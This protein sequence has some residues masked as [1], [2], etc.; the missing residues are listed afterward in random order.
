ASTQ[1][2]AVAGAAA[3][4]EQS[5]AADSKKDD[6][7]AGGGLRCRYCGKP[8][9]P[10][11]LY[12]GFCGKSVAAPV[13]EPDEDQKQVTIRLKLMQANPPV[14]GKPAAAPP[15]PRP[16][17]ASGHWYTSW[18]GN[19]R[20]VISLCLL[21]FLGYYAYQKIKYDHD[22]IIPIKAAIIRAVQ[23]VQEKSHLGL[24]G[25]A[26]LSHRLLWARFL[27]KP[28][29]PVDLPP[30]A[31]KVTPM[32]DKPTAPVELSE[33]ES[34]AEAVP[35]SK[36]SP[37]AA[38][39]PKTTETAVS[40]APVPSETPPPAAVSEPPKPKPKPEPATAPVKSPQDVEYERI[41][42]TCKQQQPKA[43]D[44]ITIRFL[45]DRQPVEGVLEQ[46]TAE[47]VKVKVPAGVIE[48]PFRLMSAESRLMYFPE[49]RARR[50]QDQQI[51]KN[52]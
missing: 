44:R 27:T 24:Q 2:T 31:P 23:S 26:Q 48:Y 49:E 42:Q 21:A 52:E 50:L 18:G 33:S 19:V 10:Q 9:Q 51:K 1:P 5:P 29:P 34:E 28:A 17:S 46:T 37:A 36:S 38:T 3:L 7:L 40:E 16:Q 35:E 39:E 32:P 12:C 15:A 13:K 14:K 6:A 45:K 30:V 25:G 22:V 11:V 8:V 41:L 43:G 4:A 20:V 47:G